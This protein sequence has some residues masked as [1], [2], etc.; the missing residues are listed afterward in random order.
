MKGWKLSDGRRECYYGELPNWRRYYLP[1]FPLGGKTVLDVGA[2]EGES[3]A[4]FLSHGAARVV[5]IERDRKCMHNLYTNAKR[6][7]ITVVAEPFQLNHL[8]IPHHFA[9]IDI[10]GWEEILLQVKPC[11]LK[12]TVVEVHGQPLMARFARLGWRY[13]TPPVTTACYMSNWK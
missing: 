5:C 2:G 13:L 3:A 11:D 8:M 12:P 6:N 1:P 9:K 7:P 10:E 4:F